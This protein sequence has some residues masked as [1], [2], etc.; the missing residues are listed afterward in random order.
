MNFFSILKEITVIIRVCKRSPAEARAKFQRLLEDVKNEHEGK[1]VPYLQQTLIGHGLEA[2]EKPGTEHL[3][4]T[5]QEPGAYKPFFDEVLYQRILPLCQLAH[6]YEQNGNP[7]EH[8]FKLATLFK[9]EK[10]IHAYLLNFKEGNSFNYLVHDAC[11]FELPPPEACQFERWKTMANRTKNNKPDWML[12]PRFRELLPHASAIERIERSGLEKTK[13]SKNLPSKQAIAAKT[14]EIITIHQEYKRVA[15]KPQQRTEEQKAEKRARLSKLGSQRSRLRLELA[16]L[17]AG[18]TL[19]EADMA[20]LQAFYEK[21]QLGSN[22]AHQLLVKYGISEKEI[23]RF[24]TLT[25]QNDDMAI[26]NLVIDGATIGYPGMY[27]KKLDTLDDRGAALAACLGKIT[28]CCQYLGNAGASCAI[29]GITSPDGG[30]YVLFKGD[31]YNSSLNDPI[32]AQAWAWRSIGGALCFD[33]IEA[34]R[35]TNMVEEIAEMYRYL[36]HELCNNPDFKH[37]KVNR[38]N[39]GS[40]SGITRNIASKEFPATIEQP[41]D[42]KGY[43][44]SMSQLLLADAT[45][46]Y[47]FYGQTTSAAFQERIK[48]ETQHYF[49]VLFET[50]AP[51]MD[52]EPLKKI[53]YCLLHNNQSEVLLA[54]LKE[55]SGVRQTELEQLVEVNHRYI[56]ALNQNRIDFTALQQGAYS[57]AINNNGEN[58]LHLAATNPESLKAILG[59]LPDAERF[60]AVKFGNKNGHTVM[61]KAATSPESL[62]VIFELLTKSER[63]QALKI[64]GQDGD[65]ILHKVVSNSESLKVILGVLPEAKRLEALK[66]SDKFGKMVLQNA[67]LIPESL[68]VIFELLTEAERLQAVKMTDQDGDSIL[69]KVASNPES[70]KI[71]LGVLP[72]AKRLEAVKMTNGH[73]HSV[74]YDASCNP[75]SLQIIL[76]VYP[77]AERL[78]AVKMNN[79]YGQNLL[80]HQAASNPESLQIILGMYPEAERLEIVK[81]TDQCGQTLLQN[82]NTHSESLKFILGLYPE[83][84]RIETVKMTDQYGRSILHKVART[85]ESLKVILE[86]YPEA[87]RL[88]AVKMSD[89]Y[90]QTLLHKVATNPASLGIIL[91]VH[92]EAERLEAVKLTDKYGNTVLQYAAENPESLQIIL[93]LY[94]ESE[95]LDTVKMNDQYGTTVLQNAAGN[96]ES[97]KRLFELLPRADRLE[98]VKTFNNYGRSILTDAIYYPELLKVIFDDI[99]ISEQ[100]I[101]ELMKGEEYK[102]FIINRIIENKLVKLQSELNVEERNELEFSLIEFYKVKINDDFTKFSSQEI[103]ILNLGSGSDGIV[104]TIFNALKRPSLSLNAYQ[105]LDKI[106]TQVKKIQESGE[107]ADTKF[108]FISELEIVFNEVT[109]KKPE[110]G[111][112]RNNH[113]F[114]KNDTKNFENLSQVA[115]PSLPL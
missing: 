4:T 47:L 78:E 18:M 11:L 55:V 27:L 99:K 22:A 92:P 3:L 20:I 96:P 37:F 91:G 53:V 74:L 40:H 29:H 52:N 14:K 90:G 87:E 41:V 95:R 111:L 113:C 76:G 46:P 68:K 57:N 67:Y 73:G 65:S 104:S 83:T 59:V 112:A 101:V 44:D 16:E 85:Y 102:G 86:V 54:Q 45:I 77:E 48:Q 10:K 6:L 88:K 103:S 26:P 42:Y 28:N 97:V 35:T 89:Q 63:H 38:I 34:S 17:C 98:A 94:P 9:D 66:I 114:F 1:G 49:K 60:I 82:I 36:A 109:E 105:S 19:E 72:E 84:E 24:N 93:E 81:M 108:D 61:H 15:G 75:E 7:K 107:D 8:A 23:A 79:K 2:R 12:N 64:A 80:L 69:H 33:S 115:H 5:Y 39:T 62:K 71:I 50:D 110:A 106:I 21:Y 51:L 56:E 32:L 58:A 100:V 31:A 70:L 30:F 43:R 25:R 13:Q